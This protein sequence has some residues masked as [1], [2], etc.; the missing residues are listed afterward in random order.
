M[1]SHILPSVLPKTKLRGSSYCGAVEM[2]R[3]S[4]QEDAGSLRGLALW[5]KDPVA[6]S[7]GVGRKC[8]SDPMLLWLWPWPA[9]EVLIQL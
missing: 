8:S 2:N 9:A 5:V 3:T 4:I 1:T 6:G 7:C